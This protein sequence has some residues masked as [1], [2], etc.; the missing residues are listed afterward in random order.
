MP[1]RRALPGAWRPERSPRVRTALVTTHFGIPST[2]V[3]SGY[4]TSWTRLRDSHGLRQ[5]E[6]S[7][8]LIDRQHSIADRITQSAKGTCPGRGRNGGRPALLNSQEETVS[9]SF[10]DLVQGHPIERLAPGDLTGTVPPSRTCW[11]L[12]DGPARGDRGPARP[13]RRRPFAAGA[14]YQIRKPADQPDMRFFAGKHGWR[15][16]HDAQDAPPRAWLG[17]RRGRAHVSRSSAII[18]RRLLTPVL[19]KIALRWSCTVCGDR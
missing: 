7:N 8:G 12:R 13:S 19:V 15:P 16:E 4:G 3:T 14:G 9:D 1:A 18:S 5:A 10:A 11:S 17:A 6:G 2:S